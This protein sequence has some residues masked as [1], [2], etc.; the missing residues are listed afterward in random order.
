L[1]SV[2]D[3]QEKSDYLAWNLGLFSLFNFVCY[4]IIPFYVQRSGATLLNISNVTTVIWSLLLDVFFFKKQFYPLYV[5]AFI[6]EMSGVVTFSLD[7]P[8]KKSGDSKDISDPL[9]PIVE[10]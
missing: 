6:F 9:K 2:F 8:T 5:V 1:S 7:K 10:I 4:S 3:S